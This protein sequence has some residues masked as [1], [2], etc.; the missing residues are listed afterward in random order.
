MALCRARTSLPSHQNSLKPFKKR[1]ASRTA[2]LRRQ[3][4][5]LQWQDT[6]IAAANGQ[7]DSKK[8]KENSSA[9]TARRRVKLHIREI[10]FALY[11]S[12]ETNTSRRCVHCQAKQHTDMCASRRKGQT[13]GHL[14]SELTQFS[15]MQESI[16]NSKS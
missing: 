11:T 15:T 9:K 10:D 7:V 6:A 3:L 13:G 2:Q 8:E 5:I 16:L 1:H 12:S 4:T 14:G